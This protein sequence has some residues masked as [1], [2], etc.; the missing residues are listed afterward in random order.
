MRSHHLTSAPIFL[1]LNAQSWIPAS[2]KIR[3][4]EWK[5]RL[6]L[7]QYIARGVP[8]LHPDVL[9]TYR[10]PPGDQPG[11]LLP[12]FH[13][14][15]DDGHTIKVVRA[16]LIAQEE[17]RRYATRPWVRIREEDWVRVHYLLLRSVEGQTMRWVRSAGFDEAWVEVPK[18]HVAGL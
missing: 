10:A 18:E 11:D 12:R 6:D 15:E 16:L 17:T 9:H 13:V 7:V 5:M 4:L 3:L 1:T 8:T 14:I 2:T